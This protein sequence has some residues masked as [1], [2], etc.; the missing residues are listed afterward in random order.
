M[1]LRDLFS[2]AVAA[3]D[4][5]MCVPPH[6]PEPPAGR[7]LVIAAG[8]A[9]ASMARAVESAWPTDLPLGGIAVTRD[10]HGVPCDRI[11][12][13]EAAHPVPDRRGREAAARAL[14][15]ARGLAADDLLLCLI[16]GGGSSLLTY[17]APGV[18]L[19][20]KQRVNKALLRSGAPIGAMN[21]VRRHLSAIKGG[22]LAAA[23][24]PAR[25]V[26]LAI[27]DVPG[28]DPGTIASGPTVPDPTTV[29]DARAALA[30][31]GIETNAPLSETPK[32]DDPCFERAT[33]QL[34][35]TPRMMLDAVV[36][37]INDINVIDLG[38]DVEG[39]AREVGA[40]HAR[41]ARELAATGEPTLILSGGETTVTVTGDGGRGGRNCEYLLALAIALD[42][43]PRIRALAAD[44]DGIDGSETNAGAVCG[45]D[46]LARSRAAGLDA[47]EHLAR[48]DSYTV[49]EALGDLVVTG[50]TRTNVNDFRAIA[51]NM[52]P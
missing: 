15:L 20:E 9:A 19:A 40:D 1:D 49:F 33:F 52:D 4:P 39:E 23:A 26:T 17:P 21:V 11:E 41:L 28:D 2:R 25:V 24:Y 36:A 35:A 13:I 3:A 14:D 8:K 32:P 10:D 30:R 37:S 42:G 22:R 47:R 31:Y 50:P 38:A 5:A 51:V 29:E 34:V 27:S 46:T 12:V 7:T 18:D 45:P 43:H 16:S 48:H 6:L 44:T